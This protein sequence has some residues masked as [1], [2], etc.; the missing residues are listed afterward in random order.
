MRS[1][2]A[3]LLALTST[4]SLDA[5]TGAAPVTNAASAD[6]AW[7]Q[8]TEQS[9]FDAIATGDHGPWERVLDPTFVITGEEGEVLTREALL[10]SM[11]GLP[12]PLT[13]KITVRE[14]TVQD[15]GSFAI[16]RFL[17]DETENVWG[18]E[19]ATKYRITDTWRRD[20]KQWKL[21]GSHA[22]VVTQDPPAQE[23]ST[24]GWPGLVGTYKLLPNG[25]T[26]TVELR[27]GKLWGGRD[28]A[29]LSPLVPM[30]PN[31][32]VVSGKLGE[33]IF[34][35]DETGKATRIVDLRKFEPLI[36]TRVESL[37]R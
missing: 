25:W 37:A 10:D 6:A 2:V 28:P 27:D 8:S 7:F 35:T 1:I 29:K 36:W 32:F 15:Y 5:A 34:V 11:H 26:F 9:L 21:V 17:A 22:S 23:V 3:I 12:P 14:L 18:Q 13:G 19:L 31:V 4:A 20:G 16:V 24:A 33:W 30:A